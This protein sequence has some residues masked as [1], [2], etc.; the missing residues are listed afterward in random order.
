MQDPYHARIPETLIQLWYQAQTLA[1]VI[2]IYFICSYENILPSAP[3][4]CERY[5][6]IS[7]RPQQIIEKQEQKKLHRG[8]HLGRKVEKRML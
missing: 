5:L 1:F 6:G 7:P 8:S 3:E 2:Y 4:T